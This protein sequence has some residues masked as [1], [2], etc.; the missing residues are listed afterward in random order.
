MLHDVRPLRSPSVD[1]SAAWQFVG[2][3]L[4]GAYQRRRLYAEPKIIMYIGIYMHC[5][6]SSC[7]VARKLFQ[8]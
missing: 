8:A 3:I 4:D 1:E 5:V 6:N 7:N 2:A